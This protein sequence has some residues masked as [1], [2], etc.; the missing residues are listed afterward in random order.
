MVCLVIWLIFSIFGVQLFSGRFYKCVD[1]D[2]NRLL[3]EVVPNKT[4]CLAKK[5]TFSWKNSDINFDNVANGF[6]ALFQVV[7]DLFKF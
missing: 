1:S 4:S 3:A 5:G 6:L 2:G 7:G